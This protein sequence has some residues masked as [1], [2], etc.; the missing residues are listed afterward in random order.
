[1]SQPQRLVFTFKPEGVEIRE[2]NISAESAA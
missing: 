2:D 1:M